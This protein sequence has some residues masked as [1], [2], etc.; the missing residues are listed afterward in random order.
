MFYFVATVL[1]VPVVI[2]GVYN[3][4]CAGHIEAGALSEGGSI[5]G[6]RHRGAAANFLDNKGFGWLMEVADDDDGD[7][8]PLLYVFVTLLAACYLLTFAVA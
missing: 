2:G 5:L 8:R 1:V 6:L 4:C 3:L 7:Q